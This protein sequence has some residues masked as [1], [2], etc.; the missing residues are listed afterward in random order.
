MPFNCVSSGT[1]ICRSISSADQPGFWAMTSTVGGDGSGYASIFKALKAKSPPI[2]RAIAQAT[3]SKRCLNTLL[4]NLLTIPL[5]PSA[6]AWC[7]GY[8]GGRR[9][10]VRADRGSYD[11][12]R[13]PDWWR[14]EFDS[15]FVAP[16]GVLRD[17]SYPG[18]TRQRQYAPT[19]RLWL[20]FR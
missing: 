1:V 20:G 7:Q 4:I 19:L 11:S 18:G 13:R 16:P 17:W 6:R 14:G 9:R 8:A 12:Q 15:V 10:P 3:M 2:R 5:T